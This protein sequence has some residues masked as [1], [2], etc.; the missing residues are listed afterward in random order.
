MR[1]QEKLTLYVPLAAEQALDVLLEGLVGLQG[2][3]SSKRPRYVYT[4]RNKR[5]AWREAVAIAS[6]SKACQAVLL[7]IEIK[8]NYDLLFLCAQGNLEPITIW[9]GSPIYL[10]DRA[11]QCLVNGG[12]V[13]PPAKFSVQFRPLV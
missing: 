5:D 4:T 11:I 8:G 7:T 12:R 1:K 2:W 6:R 9:S 13:C 10:S 3:Y